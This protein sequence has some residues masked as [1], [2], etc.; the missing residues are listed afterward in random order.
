MKLSTEQVMTVAAKMGVEP[1][2]DTSIAH[3]KLKSHF[4]D[5]TFFLG[6]VGAYVWELA[7][8]SET[9]HPKLEALQIAS[10]ADD[11]HTILQPQEPRPVG[12]EVVLD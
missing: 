4:G 7:E 9:H 2:P 12:A 10:W 8:E 3:D 11:E 6:S 5:H 1:V